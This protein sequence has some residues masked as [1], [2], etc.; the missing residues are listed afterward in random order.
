MPILINKD[1]G[2]AEQ[3][4]N[5][6][7]QSAINSSTHQVPMYD[8][9]GN[10]GAVDYTD[11]PEMTRNGYKVASPAQQQ[12]LLK[13]ATHGTGAQQIIT[14]LEGAGE[15][16]TFGLSTKAETMLG[17]NPEDILARR[18]VNPGSH[19]AGQAVGLVGSALTGVGE[20]AALEKIGAYAAEKIAPKLAQNFAGRI[21]TQAAK[22]SIENMAFQSGDEASKMFMG[23]PNQS[24]ET[25]AAE[26]GLAG[27]LGGT[28]GA[29]M[30]AVSHGWTQAMGP[31]LESALDGIA[32]RTGGMSD[33]MMDAAKINIPDD[34]RPALQGN[35]VAADA[36]AKLNDSEGYV[37]GNVKEKLQEL[38][39]SAHD[40][41]VDAMGKTPEE[42]LNLSDYE[43]GKQAQKH[44]VDAIKEV[45]DPIS[46][47]YDKLAER[48]KEAPVV[49][50][51]QA[52]M[53]QKLSDIIT[54]QGYNKI[55]NSEGANVIAQ[56]LKDLPKQETAQ[57]LRNY[58]STL[59]DENPYGSK[60][61]QAAKL[62]RGV[63]D[64]G[65]D[66]T[67]ES[68][69][70]QKSPELLAEF[71]ANQQAYK[72]FR[73][74]TSDLNDRLHVGK[75]G[76]PKSFMQAVK[77][78]APEDLIRRLSPKGDVEMQQMLEQKLPKVADVVRQTELDKI[79]KS[80]AG[81][82]TDIDPAKLFRNIGK[83][84]P[85]MKS[86]LFKPEV[87]KQLGAIE[88]LLSSIP[89]SSNS[90][91]RAGLWGMLKK[92]PPSAVGVGALLMHGG[93]PVSYLLGHLAGLVGREG[94]N[95]VRLATLKFLSSPEAVNPAGFKAAVQAAGAV[96]KG[97]SKLNMSVKSIFTGGKAVQ[98][99]SESSRMILDEHV[100]R[101]A[102][103]QDDMTNVGGHTGHYMPEHGAAIGL[104]AARNIQYLTS[105]APKPTSTGPMSKPMA[106]N[107]IAKANYDRALDIAQSPLIVTKFMKEGTLTPQDMQHFTTMYPSLHERMSDKIIQH[108]TNL[109][110]K[111][112]NIP[113]STQMSISHFL[114]QPVDS[115]MSQQSIMS[116]QTRVQAS[117]MQM[118][119][120]QP[121]VKNTNKLDK[122]PGAYATPQQSR[123]MQRAAGK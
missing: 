61:Y 89:K 94:P 11:V 82:E 28:L 60:G 96:L 99:P 5:S 40:A 16:A 107:Q 72:S 24:M 18:E 9:E 70:G 8:T 103:N 71:K 80:S 84:S 42:A 48:F 122:V 4:D 36:L 77:D 49:A 52:Q 105:I 117:Q 51:Q 83:L 10:P 27:L 46:E 75:F 20:G 30:G 1:S 62:A 2:L 91:T 17:V 88:Q 112:E 59:I 39:T 76:G 14:G 33:E 110:S 102:S 50:E 15:G 19:M 106:P 98:L 79:L 23:D 81:K 87:Q 66:A 7:A 113:Y 93:N 74:F 86:F 100:K 73:E 69:A 31:K 47:K 54:E 57:D 85:E 111:D 64:G 3:L 55:S 25:A 21:G 114:G 41:L 92:L 63:L 97:E 43:V 121:S 101:V 67:L 29:G 115:T 34:I 32:K 123:Q 104:I 38:K 109:R 56:V 35:P 12:H 37:A 44:V 68:F 118:P 78:M 90:G 119:N 58:V 26:V 13:F 6:A 65:R 53:S 120:S 116:T 22:V 95:A 108:I 45:A